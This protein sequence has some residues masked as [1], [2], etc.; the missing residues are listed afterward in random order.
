MNRSPSASDIFAVLDYLIS[1]ALLEG[2]IGKTAVSVPL[3]DLINEGEGVKFAE[4]GDG[5][6]LKVEM[7]TSW[8]TGT[9]KLESDFIEDDDEQS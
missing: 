5:L 1:K 6:I 4:A 3:V 2:R 9:E 8:D 7:K